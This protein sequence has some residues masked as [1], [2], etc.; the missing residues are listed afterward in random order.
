LAREGAVFWRNSAQQEADSREPWHSQSLEAP[1]RAPL[2]KQHFET[3]FKA[4]I[5]AAAEICD[6]NR[7]GVRAPNKPSP[8]ALAAYIKRRFD[9]TQSLP[10]GNHDFRNY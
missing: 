8:F 2:S 6:P 5:R 9:G 7:C 1:Y 4:T 3:G 10:Y